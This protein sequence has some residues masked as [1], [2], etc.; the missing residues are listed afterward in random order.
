MGNVKQAKTFKEQIKILKSRGMVIDNNEEAELILSNVNYYRFTEYLSQF[1]INDEKYKKG[2]TFSQIYNIYIF[3][4]DLRI[5]LFD[6]LGSLE[7][8]FRTY[9]SYTLAMKYKTLGYLNSKNFIN[10][11][12]HND[13][14]ERLEKKKEKNLNKLFTKHY[15][16]SYDGKLPIWVAVEIIPFGLLSQL[17]SNML[18]T[19]KSYIKN[20]FCDINVNVANTW[21]QSLTHLRNQCAHYGRI[22]NSPLPIIKIKEEYKMYNLDTKSV[23]AYIIAIKHLTVDNKV[24]DKFYNSLVTL[25]KNNEDVI[26]LKLIG[27]PYNWNEILYQ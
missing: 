5:L 26:D 3:D 21:L 23:F 16:D 25:I 4:K 6:I 7:L 15:T 8:S 18:P 20:N 2:I 11:R 1:K 14:L 19:D 13:F 17:Y 22:Y 12:Y 10:K 9:I 24:W 27:F